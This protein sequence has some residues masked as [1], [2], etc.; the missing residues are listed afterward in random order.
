MIS[1]GVEKRRFSRVF[2][3]IKDEVL[4]LFT[5]SDS[6]K[7]MITANIVN[8]SEGGLHF[9]LGRNKNKKFIGGDRLVF[10]EI[11]AKKTLEF[12]A[13]IEVEIKWVL[14]D[15]Y[16][17]HVGFGCEFVNIPDAKRKEIVQL[18]NRLF[19]VGKE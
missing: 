18:M 4:G 9:V 14:D 12:V 13:D 15:Q 2:F 3:S 6:E 11:K 8:L 16:L 17:K 5:H 1:S 7:E 19:Q 10:S